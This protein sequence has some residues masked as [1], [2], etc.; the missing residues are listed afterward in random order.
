MIITIK[1]GGIYMKLLITLHQVRKTFNDFI[2]LNDVSLEVPEGEIFGLLG[3]SGAGKTTM[4]KILTGQLK[5]TNGD[6]KVFNVNSTKLSEREYNKIGMVLDNTGLYSRLSCYDN[7]KIFADIYGVSKVEIAEALDAVKLSNAIKRPV[8][9]LSKGMMQR[10]VFA[11]A[12]LHKPKLLF[13]DEPTS[14]LDP[15]TAYEIHK[16]IYKLRDCGT[17]IFLT[18]HNMQEATKLCDNVAIMNEGKIIEYG[19]PNDICKKYNE[20]VKI[21]IELNNST[22]INLPNDDTSADKIAE[23]FRKNLVSSIHSSEPNLETVFFKLTGRELV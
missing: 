19:S 2:A 7:L 17:T 23:L 20:D 13:L 3:P 12:I 18:T 14:G 21:V 22:H 10:L 4:I 5:P 9:K 11:R 15:S 1:Q 8:S 16:L 6:S